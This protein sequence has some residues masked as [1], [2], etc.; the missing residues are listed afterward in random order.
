MYFNYNT[1]Q[2]QDKGGS[3][4]F[5]HANFCQ[6]ID[7]ITNTIIDNIVNRYYVIYGQ[8]YRFSDFKMVVSCLTSHAKLSRL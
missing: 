3:A 4:V 8:I 5:R 1:Y 2:T 6:I 7:N